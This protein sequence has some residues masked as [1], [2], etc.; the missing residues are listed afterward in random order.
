M[1]LSCEA[2]CRRGVLARVAVALVLAVSLLSPASAGEERRSAKE[3]TLPK[4]LASLQ[5]DE[6]KRAYFTDLKL[7]TQ[8]GTEVR[9][10]S[11]ILKDRVVLLS[12]FYI[13][14]KTV[15]PKQNVIL[16][17]LQS[18]LGQRLGKEVMMVSITV[19]PAR[20]TPEKVREYAK[21]FAAKKGWAFLSGKKEN[22]DWVNYKLGQ[23]TEDLESHPLIY[24][25]G[26]VKS[27]HWLKMSREATAES[28][29][30]QIFLLLEESETV[31]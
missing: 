14:C 27:G 19:D 23:Y 6:G 7:V 31:K 17:R 15:S 8:E 24:M 4:P 13:N 11:D 20:D 9:F 5:G 28:L 2:S 21:V 30:N 18:K 22:V 26:N 10:Y 29:Y 25:L 3:A 1:S 12:F 16:A